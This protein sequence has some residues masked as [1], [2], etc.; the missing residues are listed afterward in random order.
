MCTL[1]CQA[2]M[3]LDYAVEVEPYHSPDEIESC[4]Q[5]IATYVADHNNW[6]RP[7]LPGDGDCP[8]ME[9]VPERFDLLGTFWNCLNQPGDMEGILFFSTS[10]LDFLCVIH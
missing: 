9:F 5:E 1:P 2:F 4:A 10:G 7:I 3:R 6:Y 8:E